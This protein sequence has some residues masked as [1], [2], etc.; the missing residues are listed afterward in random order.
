MYVV[1]QGCRFEA[2]NCAVNDIVMTTSTDGIHWSL[3]QR[4]PAD[5]VGQR[6]GPSRWP[7]RPPDSGSTEATFT[8]SGPLAQL[9]GGTLQPDTD[10]NPANASPKTAS[11]D[12]ANPPA[13]LPLTSR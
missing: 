3:V 8:D 13:T 9:T 1:W 6:R 10:T 11:P 2:P 4:I 5:P 12:A 7:P